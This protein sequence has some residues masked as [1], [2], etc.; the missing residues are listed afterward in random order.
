MLDIPIDL[1]TATLPVPVQIAFVLVATVVV[2][3]IPAWLLVE[4]AR[5]SAQTPAE[6]RDVTMVRRFLLF[7][8]PFVFTVAVIV[9]LMYIVL[10]TW[11]ILRSPPDPTPEQR[12]GDSARLNYFPG[13]KY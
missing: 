10:G 8:V 6:L 1:S 12:D 2:L 3:A 4:R 9:C 11:D 13:E 7:L 5:S